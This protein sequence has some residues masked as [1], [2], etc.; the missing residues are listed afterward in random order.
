MP[1]YFFFCSLIL[2]LNNSLF[3]QGIGVSDLE[4][5][6][7]LD[8]SEIETFLNNKGLI[9]ERIETK[10]NYS[11]IIYINPSPKFWVATSTYDDS[12]KVFMCDF[13]DTKFYNLQKSQATQNGFKY[14]KQEIYNDNKST[15]GYSYKSIHYLYEKDGNKL[16]FISQVFDDHIQ[17]EISYNLKCF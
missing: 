16:T 13:R 1:K 2:I 7:K 6:S 15:S 17:Y 11:M 12:C 8:G 5:L 10:E 4:K 9:I 3:G 14:I